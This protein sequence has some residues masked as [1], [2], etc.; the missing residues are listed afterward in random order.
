MPAVALTIFCYLIALAYAF[1]GAMHVANL[2]GF[3]PPP[4][5]G[6]ERVFRALDMAYLL[7]NALV[8]IG[9]TVGVTWGYAAFFAAAGSQLVLYLGFTDYFASDADQRRQLR[10]LVGFHLTTAT[11]MATLLALT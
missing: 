3:G 9:M 7:V 8:V 10:G 4:P 5:P 11:A 6:K 1:G 2:S